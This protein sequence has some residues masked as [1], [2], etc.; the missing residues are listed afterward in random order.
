MQSDSLFTV[1]QVGNEKIFFR[2]NCYDPLEDMRR[3]VIYD[4]ATTIEALWR[5]H[6]ARRRYLHVR[7]IA[8]FVQFKIRRFLR[9]VRGRISL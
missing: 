7:Y 4:A 2:Q 1:M 9:L 6:V 5:M 8:L 3:Q